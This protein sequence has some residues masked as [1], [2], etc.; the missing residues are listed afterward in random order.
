MR[1]FV[2]TSLALLV[3]M[4]LCATAQVSISAHVPRAVWLAFGGLKPSDWGA[5]RARNKYPSPYLFDTSLLVSSNLPVSCRRPTSKTLGALG[6]HRCPSSI[7]EGTVQSS[8][9]ADVSAVS[10]S[11]KFPRCRVRTRVFRWVC[12]ADSV[13]MRGNM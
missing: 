8:K 7:L 3:G 4:A 1:A 5:I 2:F 6:R 9:S 13:H 12:N 10:G 11:F